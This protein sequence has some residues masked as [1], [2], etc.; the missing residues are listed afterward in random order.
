MH[1]GRISLQ[2]HIA[3]K[4]RHY[5]GA[6]AR[7]QLE[8]LMKSQGEFVLSEED[9]VT[10]TQRVRNELSQ[11]EQKAYFFLLSSIL[12][13]RL[14]TICPQI[15]SDKKYAEVRARLAGLTHRTDEYQHGISIID[16]MLDDVDW[17]YFTS[18]ATI[19]PGVTQQ[20]LP[21]HALNLEPFMQDAKY[22]V[23]ILDH[24]GIHDGT[25]L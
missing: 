14:A 8:T 18:Y 25:E 10:I 19:P 24:I 9:A 11:G 13:Q 2:D 6:V 12:R 23:V 20:E 1:W 7:G 4:M 3:A 17:D 16:A 22:K 21:R 15:A 5:R